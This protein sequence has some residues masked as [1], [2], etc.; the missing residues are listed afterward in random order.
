MLNIE[1]MALGM[2]VGHS[3]AFN[4]DTLFKNREIDLVLAL[5]VR[6]D[7]KEIAENNPEY[8]I[9]VDKENTIR[10]F[11]KHSDVQTGEIRFTA[12]FDI[13]TQWLEIL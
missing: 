6:L 8:V 2:V 9:S 3:G 1:S 5:T 4:V 12:Y 10:Y 11:A 13:K 7:E